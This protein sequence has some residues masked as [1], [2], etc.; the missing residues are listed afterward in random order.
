[1]NKEGENKREGQTCLE[2][3]LFERTFFVKEK[4]LAFDHRLPQIY[5]IDLTECY[6][7]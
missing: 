7:D 3:Y 4:A 2:Y 5:G 6:S 1:M